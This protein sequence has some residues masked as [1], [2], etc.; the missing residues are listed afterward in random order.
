MEPNNCDPLW[1]RKICAFR[2]MHLLSMFLLAMGRSLAPEHHYDLVALPFVSRNKKLRLSIVLPRGERGKR[3][4]D[5]LFRLTGSEELLVPW[6]SGHVCPVET[7]DTN[8]RHRV[9]RKNRRT[10][11]HYINCL[12]SKIPTKW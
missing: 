11:N 9:H 5:K 12:C 10:R 2:Q 3:G 4:A 6:H 8:A 7:T 1:I